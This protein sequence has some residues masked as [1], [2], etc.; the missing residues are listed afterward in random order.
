MADVISTHFVR[1]SNPM[2]ELTQ[3]SPPKLRTPIDIKVLHKI[4]V[5]SATDQLGLKVQ[6]MIPYYH[7]QRPKDATTWEDGFLRCLFYYTRWGHP[8]IPRV[9]GWRRTPPFLKDVSFPLYFAS[10]PPSLSVTVCSTARWETPYGVTHLTGGSKP[11]NGRL[12]GEGRRQC[13]NQAARLVSL[14]GWHFHDLARICHWGTDHI[15]SQSEYIR[16]TIEAERPVTMGIVSDDSTLSLLK[17]HLLVRNPPTNHLLRRHPATHPIS[18]ETSSH[19]SNKSGDI[20]PP[21]Q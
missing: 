2:N 13:T 17:K 12:W 18:Q 19:P 6:M 5:N 9:A 16:F 8:K 21:S 20:Q 7:P 15:N 11:G 1:V 4:K 10:T 14:R 3:M